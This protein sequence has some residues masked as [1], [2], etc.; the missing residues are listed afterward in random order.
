MHLV[1]IQTVC[2]GNCKD[3]VSSLNTDRQK[4]DYK[5]HLISR[6]LCQLRTGARALLSVAVG[7]DSAGGGFQ[8]ATTAP[9]HSFHLD[10]AK[11]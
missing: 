1:K 4:P 5:L 6:S 2:G 3:G 9:L 7:L 10:A 8:T 11:I